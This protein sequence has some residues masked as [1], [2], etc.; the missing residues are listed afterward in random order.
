MLGSRRILFASSDPGGALSIGALALRLQQQGLEK[1]LYLTDASGF[2]PFYVEPIMRQVQ[3]W[4]EV[5][6]L[7]QKFKPTHVVVGTSVASDLEKR[8]IA[9]ARSKSI[10]SSAFV[11]HWT[12]FRD[13]FDLNGK[14]ELPDCIFVLDSEAKRQAMAE[15]F[16]AQSL[17]ICGNPY[18]DFLKDFNPRLSKSD[19]YLKY[20][21]DPTQELLLFL[22]DSLEESFGG[23]TQTR[24]CL[25][26]DEY[27]I[28][29]WIVEHWRRARSSRGWQ[30][31]VKLHPKENP[32]KF[33]TIL[34]LEI[35]LISS[36][37]FSLELIKYSDLNVGMFTA[38][39]IESCVLGTPCVRLE[40]N[41][42]WDYL[43]ISC[44]PRCT[45]RGKAEALL[46]EPI[47]AADSKGLVFRLD[48]WNSFLS[49]R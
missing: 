14:I 25:G 11:D 12:R 46:S 37:E 39:L 21:L 22:S 42:K 49:H 43:P 45:K 28:L 38:A 44:I 30:L 8:M 9:E 6:D 23:R 31:A 3:T 10:P 29:D 2:R 24:A 4:I 34:P 13:R 47:A 26:Y 17:R 18:W 27:E 20:G 36:S 15:G 33:A 35:H 7:W 19:I 41:A 32:K 1:I 40:W 16:G 5:L 48:E